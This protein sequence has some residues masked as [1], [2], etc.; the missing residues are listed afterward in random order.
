MKTNLTYNDKIIQE[1]AD[2]IREAGPQNLATV[3]GEIKQLK[4]SDIINSIVS[5]SS[6]FLKKN[7][8]QIIVVQ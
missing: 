1:V 4:A 8:R 6:V 7:Y 5:T 2:I 3:V